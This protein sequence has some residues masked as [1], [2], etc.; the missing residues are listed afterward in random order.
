MK[1]K[2]ATTITLPRRN[3]RAGATY[4]IKNTATDELI[5]VVDQGICMAPGAVATFRGVDPP[6]W[7]RLVAFLRRQPRP[8]GTW[9][10]VDDALSKEKR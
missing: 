1:L 3:I 10:Y 2:D 6:L 5:R 9:R 8:E 7:A 4:T